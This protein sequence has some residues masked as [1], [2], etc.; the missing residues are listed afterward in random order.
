[1]EKEVY[2]IKRGMNSRVMFEKKINTG[3]TCKCVNVYVFVGTYTGIYLSESILSKTC[4]FLIKILL[5]VIMHK[6]LRYGNE[7]ANM[8]IDSL[9]FRFSI[10]S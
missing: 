2:Y 4:T 10:H 8:I 5:F 6:F 3:H 1:M 9:N 7:K